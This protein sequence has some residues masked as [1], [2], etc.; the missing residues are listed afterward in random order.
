MVSHAARGY[1][2]RKLRALRASRL[3]ERPLRRPTPEEIKGTGL[4]IGLS[5]C[6][7]WPRGVEVNMRAGSLGK[8]S[9]FHDYVNVYVYVLLG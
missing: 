2:R 4:G 8:F 3:L 5:R 7:N 9:E 1:L 6:L